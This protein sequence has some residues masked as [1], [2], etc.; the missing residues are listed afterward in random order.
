[1]GKKE[2]V[3]AIDIGSSKI[4]ALIAIIEGGRINIVG[5]GQH[6]ST[7]VE[8]GQINN[9]DKTTSDIQ[10]A[11]NNA[12]LMAG[13]KFSKLYVGISGGRI[14]TTTSVGM[15]A[16]DQGNPITKE[17]VGRV[18]EQAK[19]MS[20]PI[21]HE[22]S[23]IIP[24]EFKVNNEIKTNDPVGMIGRKLEGEMKIITISSYSIQNIKTCLGKAHLKNTEFVV[25]PIASA[26]ATFDDN[27]KKMG[28]IM[29]DI[30]AETT[31]IVIYED[32]NMRYV[33]V[34][35]IGGEFITKDIVYGLNTTRENAENF[36]I[37]YGCAR[38]DMV[39]DNEI[40]EVP[41]VSGRTP[42]KISKQEFIQIIEPRV[43]EILEL[44]YKKIIKDS[45]VPMDKIGAGLI[46]TGGT[47]NL[48]GI[49]E[50]GEDIFNLRA[51]IGNPSG[52]EG[53]G[54]NIYNPAFSTVVGLIKYAV[55]EREIIGGK[56][57]KIVSPQEGWIKR[58]FDWL[59]DI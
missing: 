52:I 32:G 42:R 3:A 50:L 54:D 31:D 35:E 30:G 59:K 26:Y 16:I 24:Q 9:I 47:A 27:E 58:I 25:N 40:I 44:A 14:D 29:L 41:G 45:D 43:R 48:P 13:M 22:I 7:G 49:S 20:L 34:V 6:P 11:V 4:V 1:M 19:A 28:A 53:I 5:I 51:R 36:K 17:D 10:E 57:R 21:D 56:E 8:K 55:E 15:V 37:N 46:L 33:G 38:T 23:H 39:D 2:T 18:V 12:G